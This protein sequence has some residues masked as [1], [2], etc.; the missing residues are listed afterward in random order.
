VSIPDGNGTNL[1]TKLDLMRISN[2]HRMSA[3]TGM[4]FCYLLEL[5]HKTYMKT[6]VSTGR[7]LSLK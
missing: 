5:L 6:H 2:K 4:Y 7:H 1:E 3:T